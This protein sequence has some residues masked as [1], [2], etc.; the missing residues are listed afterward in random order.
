MLI[1]LLRNWVKGSDAGGAIQRKSQSLGAT[2][3][4]YLAWEQIDGAG[5]PV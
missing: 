3:E 1:N 2:R 4:Y 5:A